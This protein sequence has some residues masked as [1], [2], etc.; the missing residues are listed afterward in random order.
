MVI[1]DPREAHAAHAP[2]GASRTRGDA[3]VDA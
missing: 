2:H 1:G 3:R